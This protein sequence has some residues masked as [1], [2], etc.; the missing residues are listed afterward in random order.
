MGEGQKGRNCS[1]LIDYKFTLQCAQG[2]WKDAGVRGE[3]QERLK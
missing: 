1:S 2:K 3:R